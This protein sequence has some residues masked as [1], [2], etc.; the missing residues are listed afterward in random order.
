VNTG[1]AFAQI[2]QST[3]L[4]ASLLVALPRGAM[5]VRSIPTD[6]SVRDA[7]EDGLSALTARPVEGI[8]ALHARQPLEAQLDRFTVAPSS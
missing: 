2:Q 6:K 3:V 5:Q 4:R 8:D 1:I 7:S